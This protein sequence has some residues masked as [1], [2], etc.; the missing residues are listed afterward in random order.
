[1]QPLGAYKGI[2]FYDDSIATVPDATIAALEAL[3]PNVQTLILGG[4]ERNLD[5]TQ[6]AEALPSNIRTLILFPTTGVRIWQAVERHS[7]NALLPDAFFVR[8]MEQAVKLAYEH[9]EEGKICLMSPAAPS[10]G[11]FKDYRERGDLFNAFV[12]KLSKS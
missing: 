3:G 12:R 6:L 5:F 1:M 7:R 8:D 4:H 9:T 11:I 10:F 2:H